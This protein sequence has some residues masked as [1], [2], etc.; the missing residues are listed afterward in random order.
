MVAGDFNTPHHTWVYPRNERKEADPWK[1]ASDLNRT[2]VKDPAF[3]TRTDN[4]CSRDSTPDL[5]FVGSGGKISWVN[6]GTDLCSDHCILSKT[7]QVQRR[8]PRAFKFTDW[9]LFRKIRSDR[10]DD[11]GLTDFD[12]WISQAIRYVETATKLIQQTLS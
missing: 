3:T 12:E 2:L 7:I 9:H 5:T 11:N 4:S 1:T 8:L 6:L 10:A